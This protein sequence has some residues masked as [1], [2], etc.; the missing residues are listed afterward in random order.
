MAQDN[1]DVIESAWDAFVRGDVDAATK[2]ADDAAE[3]VI[4]EAVPWGGTYRGP[5]GFREFLAKLYESF[6]EL[7]PAPEKILGADDDHVV[8][9]A[10]ATG[11]TKAGKPFEG[12]SAWLYRLQDGKVTEVEQFLD[13]AKVLEALAS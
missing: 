9:I 7:K 4:P 13:T 3:V 11:K 10:H 5:E 12:R 2:V 6:E 8:V 1:V